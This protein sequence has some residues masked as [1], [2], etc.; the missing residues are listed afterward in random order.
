MTRKRDRVAEGLGAATLAVGVLALGGAPRWA[1][2]STTALALAG[3]SCFLIARRSATSELIPFL[4]VAAALTA[5]QWIPLPAAFVQVASHQ[6]Y[7]LMRDNSRALSEP[8]ARFFPLSYDPPATLLELMKL[9]GY[10][11]FGVV[12]VRLAAKDRQRQ[13]IVLACVGAGCTLAL[14]AVI[15]ALGHLDEVYGFY[16]LDQAPQVLLGPVVNPNHLAAVLALVAPVTI[17]LAIQARGPRRLLWA[18]ATLLLIGGTLLTRSR[19]GF[20]GL[21]VAL[22]AGVLFWSLQHRKQRP[23]SHGRVSASTIV[24]AGIVGICALVL[25]GAGTAGG[26][27]H[28]LGGTRSGEITGSEGKAEIWEK[29][30]PLANQN[31]YTGVGRGA[32]GFAFTRL[33]PDAHATRTHVENEYLQAVIDWGIVGAGLVAALFVLLAFKLLRQWDAGPVETGI[34]AGLLGLAA[35]SV[36]DFSL[37]IPG[38]ALPA[39]GLISA[40]LPA[41]LEHR[42]I[43]RP[44]LILLR[45][46]LLVPSVLLLVVAVTPMGQLARSES[47]ALNAHA[48]PGVA[49]AVDAWHQHPSDYVL[50]GI[51]AQQM[52]LAHDERSIAVLNRAL[53]LNPK[54]STLHRLAAR[55]LY[56]FGKRDQALVEISLALE[57]AVHRRDLVDSLVAMFPAAT[58]AA[59]G[60]PTD[61]L[62]A[63]LEI[64]DL[65]GQRGH[66]DVAAAAAAHLHEAYPTE[67]MPLMAIARL[68][69]GRGDAKSAREAAERAHQLRA[70]A[71]SM[72][73]VAQAIAA[74]GDAATAI[75]MLE[76]GLA[77]HKIPI[78]ADQAAAYDALA[79]IR[80]QTGDLNKARAN[81]LQLLSL[82]TNLRQRAQVHRRIAQLEQRRGNFRQAEIERN[83]A[84]SQESA[85]KRSHE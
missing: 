17:A 39:I 35:H 10:A 73:L 45:G 32:F 60:V 79:R 31:L 77:D 25:V 54:D 75:N 63:A 50:A 53:F 58:D 8:L 6:K 65:L 67:P 71:S 16:A 44:R 70:D 38:V 76:N 52:L 72:I 33:Q 3:A 29:S 59:R 26:L 36:F 51:T 55:A 20:L 41:Q 1:A 83:R 40:L 61:D 80:I 27:L 78:R 37:Q 69:L 21:A 82:A 14:L 19:G 24:A 43:G 22:L 30:A 84:R 42:A 68:A 5:L 66:A 47:L 62:N 9:I 23:R 15:H 48:K 85:A 2:L 49:A 11:A 57:D 28:D 13:R 12:C 34:V 18:G 64:I 7:D 74:E 56:D 81:L 4:V 46:R